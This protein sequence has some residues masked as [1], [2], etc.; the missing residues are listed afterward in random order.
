VKNS[1]FAYLA[2]RC[3][4]VSNSSVQMPCKSGSPQGD[5]SAAA[6][7]AVP[8]AAGPWA[9]V[10]TTDKKITPTAAPAMENSLIE[11]KNISRMMVSFS[12][13][14]PI[15]AKPWV[16]VVRAASDEKHLDL[17][18]DRPSRSGLHRGPQPTN[19]SCAFRSAAP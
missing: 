15:N 2:G 1:W 8:E 14:R 11:P 4:G 10:P 13:W 19:R 7:G 16:I 12:V 9:S 5:F 3:K 17:L 18:A 6:A